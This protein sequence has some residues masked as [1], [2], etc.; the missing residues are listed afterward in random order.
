MDSVLYYDCMKK[1]QQIKTNYFAVIAKCGHVGRNWYVVKTLYIKAESGK[2]AA[3][4]ARYTPR[5]KHD[6]KDAIRDVVKITFE[7]YEAGKLKMQ[8]DPYFQIHN[9]TEQRKRECISKNEIFKEKTVEIGI[10]PEK[11]KQ[12]FIFNL[13]YCEA[14]KMI[15]EGVY[16][17]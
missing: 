13:N 6:H 17:R 15:Q 14:G 8:N 3:K 1:A 16:D 4:I 10:K 9:S 5:V 12:R 2:E 7:E 11:I